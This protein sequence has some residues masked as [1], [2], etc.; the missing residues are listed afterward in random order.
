M[1]AAVCVPSAAIG[2]QLMSGDDIPSWTLLLTFAATTAGAWALSHRE[3]GRTFVTMI[4]VAAQFALHALFSLGQATAATAPRGAASFA[5][6]WASVL[7]CGTPAA[8]LSDG[9]ARLVRAAGLSGRLG[10]PPP[11]THAMAGMSSMPATGSMR[12]M[13]GHSAMPA[14][15]PMSHGYG[16]VG[17]VA[18]H[19]LV[20][21]LCGIWLAYGERTAFRIGRVIAT[22]ILTPVLLILWTPRA[23]HRLR[24]RPDR[25]RSARRPRSL[26]LTHVIATRGPPRAMAAGHA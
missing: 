11:A 12:G 4:T 1:F 26:L 13:P 15:A 9:A 6:Q 5:R 20:A 16:A 14:M 25:A 2:H 21:V 8:A 22:R 3:R 24:V 18:A 17:M 7:L 10:S 23:S 19:L